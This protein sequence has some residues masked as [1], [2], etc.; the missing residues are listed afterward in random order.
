MAQDY[1]R[2]KQL[3]RANRYTVLAGPGKDDG[4][5]AAIDLFG[6]PED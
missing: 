1:L 3:E 4:I 5:V 6:M 2:F